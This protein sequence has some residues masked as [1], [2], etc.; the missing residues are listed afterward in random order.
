[1]LVRRTREAFQA[2]QLQCI[3]TSATLAGSGSFEEQRIE[4][5]RV[6]SIIFGEKVL[7]SNVIG[8]TLRRSTTEYDFSD[9]NQLLKLINCIQT[10]NIPQEFEDFKNHPLAS[11]VESELGL[12][13]D[14]KGNRLVRARP[15]SL[16]GKEGVAQK[17]HHLTQLPIN[18]CIEALQTILLQGYTITNPETH[19][20]VFAFRLHQFISRGDTVYASLEEEEKRHITVHGQIYVPKERDKVLLPLAFC[21]EC[22]QEY[23]VVRKTIDKEDGIELFLPRELN[24]N[25]NSDEGEPGFLYLSTDNPWPENEED[26]LDRVPEDWLEFNSQDELVVKR[27]QRKNRPEAFYI[28]PSAKRS[29]SGQRVAFARAPFRFCLNCGVSYDARQS[30]DFA[31]L[32]E[33]SSGGRSTDTTIPF[34]IV[35][36]FSGCI[37]GFS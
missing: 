9:P 33:L 19:F 5:A 30:S 8:E 10:K 2:Y 6:A 35:S 26:Y 34:F 4:V 17:L 31:K 11:W 37:L 20:P 27:S 16:T 12:T 7:P 1:M 36:F 21:R 23:Y 3:G 24:E 15:N 13:M 28:N 32:T 18:D 25:R 22:G 14:H 29:E